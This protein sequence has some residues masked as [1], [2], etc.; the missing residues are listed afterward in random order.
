[1]PPNSRNPVHTINFHLLQGPDTHLAQ[2]NFL[3]CQSDDI[4]E[5]SITSEFMGRNGDQLQAG[6]DELNYIFFGSSSEEGSDEDEYQIT[7][8]GC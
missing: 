2:E 8:E 1:M 3:R 5:D 7:H 6:E 4:E